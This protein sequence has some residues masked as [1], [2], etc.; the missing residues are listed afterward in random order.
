MFE[1]YERYGFL[2][3]LKLQVLNIQAL[4]NTHYSP[5]L[6]CPTSYTH[7]QHSQANWPLTIETGWLD[8]CHITKGFTTRCHTHT[9]ILTSKKSP[10]ASTTNCFPTLPN[11]DIGWVHVLIKKKINTFSNPYFLIWLSLRMESD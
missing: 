4:H 2:S 10:I 11:L 5:V 1:N 6:L 9:L 8:G 3:L 7:C